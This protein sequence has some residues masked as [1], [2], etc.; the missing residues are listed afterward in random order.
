MKTLYFYVEIKKN[1]DF[2]YCKINSEKDS[3]EICATSQR[4][5]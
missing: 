1:S 4:N 5:C 3:F 2:W